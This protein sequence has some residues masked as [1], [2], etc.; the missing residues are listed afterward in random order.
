MS[1]P[2]SDQSGCVVVI[3]LVIIAIVSFVKNKNGKKEDRITYPYNYSI[4][5]TSIK[6]DSDKIVGKTIKKKTNKLKS[7]RPSGTS[8]NY[9]SEYLTPV[10]QYS[11]SLRRSS[12]VSRS[13]SSSQC[14]GTTKKGARCRNMTRSS[15]GYCWRHGG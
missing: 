12:S 5:T 11:P 4:D 1:K 15:N 7:K 8:N 10:K 6:K 3:I 9:E 2:N 14:L 13:Y